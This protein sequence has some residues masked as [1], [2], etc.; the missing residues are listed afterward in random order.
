M[1][2]AVAFSQASSVKISSEFGLGTPFSSPSFGYESSPTVAFGAGV[3]LA[4]WSDGRSPESAAVYATRIGP[5]GV[6]LDGLSIPVGAKGSFVSAQPLFNG[7][8]FL[9]AW[10]GSGAGSSD[11]VGTFVDPAG[12]VQV[13]QPT[14]F[15]VSPDDQPAIA[16]DGTNFLVTW[17]SSNDLFGRRLSAN[18]VILDL[19]PFTV[20]SEPGGQRDSASAFGGGQFL[21]V[22][23]DLRGVDA[24]VYGARVT[25]GGVV[26]DPSG[27]AISTALGTQWGASVG[28]DGASFLVAWRDQR[29]GNDDVYGGRVSSAGVALDPGG[30]AISNQPTQEFD[31]SVSCRSSECLV[32]W[33]DGRG[34]LVGFDV[35]GTRVS[36]SGQVLDPPG[37]RLAPHPRSNGST[38]APPFLASDG[39]EYLLAWQEGLDDTAGG[40]WGQ[41]VSAEAVP[42][43]AG[44]FP[45]SVASNGQ[46]APS[47]AGGGGEFFAAWEDFR[48]GFS[49]IYGSRVDGSGNALDPSGVPISRISTLPPVGA[50]KPRSRP[51][52]A[53]NGAGYYVVWLS[54]GAGATDDLRGARITSTGVLVDPAG[55]PLSAAAFWKASPAIAFDGTQF[56]VAW[57]DYQSGQRNVSATRVKPDGTA[58]DPAGIAVSR[59][60]WTEDRVAIASNGAGTLVAWDD[61]RNGNTDLFAARIDSNGTVLDD[62]GIPLSTAAQSQTGAAL[63]SNGA[64]YFAAWEDHRGGSTEI[65]GARL[66]SSGVLLDP[67]G[68]S[69]GAAEGASTSVAVA[70]DG[71]FYNVVWSGQLPDGGP[72]LLVRSVDESGGLDGGPEIASVGGGLPGGVAALRA[73][74]GRALV[75]YGRNDLVPP[76]SGP[77]LKGRFLT[78]LLQP[79]G[80]ACL[81]AAECSSA[82][83]SSGWCGPPDGGGEPDA[84]GQD[85]GASLDGGA[86]DAG[87]FDSGV[88]D[89][90]EQDG[91]LAPEDAGSGDLI[92]SLASAP[93][94]LATCG[95]TF[96]YAPERGEAELGEPRGYS[97]GG[98]ADSEVPEGLAVDPTT[99][100][101]TWTPRADQAG[102]Y[103]LVLEVSGPGGGF[104]QSWKLTVQCPENQAFRVSCGCGATRESQGPL[105][106]LVFACWQLVLFWYG[107]P[108]RRRRQAYPETNAA[109]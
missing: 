35:Y 52:V 32:A 106:G 47:V 19:V 65:V 87:S 12:G 8:N 81:D 85:A 11:L 70:F 102:N 71:L 46:S 45:V 38:S 86:G 108:R 34:P 51:A 43:D 31:P 72:Y 10:T 15:V 54:K 96:R 9:V 92:P 49:E 98:T 41:R 105:P 2:G 23:R 29:T 64:D 83:C 22:W 61:L 6:V 59:G 104:A 78:R 76:S 94:G 30:F 48:S 56:F 82:A 44:F 68:I 40:I 90:G 58:L 24:D 107:R 13:G 36:Q 75:L 33:K 74:S 16:F 103:L 17:S 79:D 5:S 84:G 7:T 1:N 91:G 93:P 99:G 14:T 50:T 20:S 60:N 55:I 21:V 66:T 37:V 18:G 28:W 67:L 25:P 4:V 63:A 77:R 95:V 69:I 88:P 26:L 3:Y 62:G 80:F 73:A 101:V 53:W 89:A 39:Q 97:V 27:I 42:S 100:E 57:V 109:G